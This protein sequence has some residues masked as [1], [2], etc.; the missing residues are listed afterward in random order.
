MLTALLKRN[1]A[2]AENESKQSSGHVRKHADGG[3]K[4]NCPVE[5]LKGVFENVNISV[6]A[7]RNRMKM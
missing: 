3:Q 4:E 6:P 5:D 7:F 1:H 2:F